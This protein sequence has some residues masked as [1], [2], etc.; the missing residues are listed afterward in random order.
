MLYASHQ[1]T[2]ETL[3]HRT[4]VAQ[5]I[6]NLS[7]REMDALVGKLQVSILGSSKMTLLV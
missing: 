5:T 4:K 7:K 1:L 2:D 3:A 6:T